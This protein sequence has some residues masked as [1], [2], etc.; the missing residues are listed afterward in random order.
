[1]RIKIAGLVS[2]GALLAASPLSAQTIDELRREM[3]EMRRAYDAELQR[4]RRDYETRL[5][6]LETRAPPATAQPPLQ[7]GRA[8]PPDM[9]TSSMPPASPARE[10][11]STPGRQP[12]QSVK[13]TPPRTPANAS[14][15]NPAI[16]VVLDGRFA[17]FENVPN[18]YSIPGIQFP[19]AAGLGPVGFG[20]GESEIN[21]SA[22]VD[23][24]LYGQLTV[25]LDGMGAA[26]V[27][28]A[29][30]ETLALPFGFTLKGGRFFSGFGYLNAVHRHAWDFADAA[31]PYRAFLSN[32]YRDDGVQVRWVA[33]FPFFLEVGGEIFRGGNYPFDGGHTFAGSG[34]GFLRVG[35]D[36]N[37]RMSWRLGLS[38]LRGRALART[39]D[40]G[41]V[42]FQ[43]VSHITALDAVFKWAPT[44]NAAEE[45]FRLQGEL[46]YREDSGGLN[47]A[48][49]LSPGWGWYAQ[50]VWRFLP[51][52]EV[53]VRFDQVF[54]ENFG[55][56]MAD[57]TLLQGWGQPRG[58]QSAALTYYTSEFG[59]FRLQVNRDHSSG[60]LVDHQFFL[61]YTVSLGAHA[62]HRY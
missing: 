2:I 16:G 9:T 60:L 4:M 30:F 52:W 17:A 32:Q 20:I 10:W 35:D 49:F 57:G 15:F 18:F 19:A 51:S 45:H 3:R 43:G 34:G 50:A 29:F 14:S 13:A 1:M 62:P 39:T 12:V 23:S 33:P 26:S 40:G 11:L 47:G 24:V 28:E 44:G 25:A 61:Q 46:M 6:N 5:Q 31:L 59:R 48:D 37:E 56:A 58:R 21:F 55:N 38:H 53:G 42:T 8:P 27:E 54:V 41:A 22:N 7:P 36:I